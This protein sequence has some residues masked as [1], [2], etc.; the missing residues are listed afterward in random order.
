MGNAVTGTWVLTLDTD[1]VVSFTGTPS[2]TGPD[3]A[4]WYE[5]FDNEDCPE[6][7]PT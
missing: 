2:P 5:L 7:E 1:S 4:G 6:V 3:T